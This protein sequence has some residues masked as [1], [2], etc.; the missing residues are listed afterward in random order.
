MEIYKNLSGKSGVRH[1]TAGSNFIDVVFAG[2]PGVFR[3][4]YERSGKE[5]IEAMKVLAETGYIST[6]PAVRDYFI[7]G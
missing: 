2:N 7:A 1:F 3:Y 6:H 5:H 4:T